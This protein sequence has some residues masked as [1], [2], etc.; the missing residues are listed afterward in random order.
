MM[1]KRVVDI[2]EFARRV[3]QV[4]DFILNKIPH[5]DGSADIRVI[6]DLKEDAADLQTEK[7][8]FDQNLLQGLKDHMSIR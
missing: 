7:K 6:Q 8:S 5:K 2:E 1:N 4:C 3:E